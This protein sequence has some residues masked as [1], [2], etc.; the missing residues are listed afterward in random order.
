[1]MLVRLGEVL[2]W[3]ACGLAIIVA[4]AFV[5]VVFRGSEAGLRD[6]W[7]L[8]VITAGIWAGGIWLAGRAILYVLAGR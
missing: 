6:H 7:I 4:L 5:F 8:V 1:M 3:L 2:Y